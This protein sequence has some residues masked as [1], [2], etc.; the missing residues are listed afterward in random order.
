MVCIPCFSIV[1]T[2]EV[3]AIERFGKFQRFGPAGCVCFLW[4]WETFRHKESL[5]QE[6]IE[7]TL[8]TKTVD[9]VFVDV[10]VACNYQV[11]RN[12]LYGAYY[13]LEN[14]KQQMSAYIRDGIRTSICSM[15]LD[16]AYAGKEE[17]SHELKESL[18][19][20]FKNY[21]LIVLNVLIRE[22]LP[23][24]KV[25]AAMNEINASKRE[26][27]AAL[28]RAEG[29]KVIKIKR[30]EAE[31]EAMLLSGEGVARQRKAIM[32]G[33]KNSI[34]DFSSKV[35][36]TS[37]KDV[38]DLLILNQY[39]DALE[40]IGSQSNMRTIMLPS[41]ANGNSIRSNLMEGMEGIKTS[42]P[43]RAK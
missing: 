25:M 31:A 14:R 8:K 36:D 42:A 12:N 35:E 40:A 29:E 19:G 16:A 1:A 7:V 41:D 20:V 32:D 22:L 26:L 21:G 28:Q 11:D 38:M 27:E 3:V 37:P 30:A 24:S 23:D 33:L 4:P 9:N 15:T 39:F 34:V 43:A 6:T 5:R 2:S 13:K 10:L 18:A 17:V